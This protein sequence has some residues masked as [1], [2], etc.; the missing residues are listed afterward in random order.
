MAG[1]YR[2]GNGRGL[3]R[4]RESVRRLCGGIKIFCE[5]GKAEGK[6]SYDRTRSR[7]RNGCREQGHPA[8]F[9]DKQGLN[10][11]VAGRA[12]AE[13]PGSDMALSPHDSKAIIAQ[14]GA[15]CFPARTAGLPKRMKEQKPTRRS[16]AD[17]RLASKRGKTVPGEQDF[18]FRKDIFRWFEQDAGE[19]C[20]VGI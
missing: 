2:V 19:F 8:D 6:K 18:I 20:G 3:K 15:V 7:T 12:S 17:A 4:R 9:G 13:F 11:P 14:A 5:K 1:I 10:A 16:P